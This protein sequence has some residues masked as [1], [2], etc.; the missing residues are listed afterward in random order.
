[1]PPNYVCRQQIF[2]AIIAQLCQATVNQD[3]NETTLTITGPG[4]IGKTSI[5]TALCHHHKIQQQFSDGF[6]FIELGPQATDPSMKLFQLYHLLKG[7]YLKTSDIN[8]AGKII[9]EL[10]H[11]YSHNLLVIIDD[12]WHVEDA[13]PIVKT[14]SKCKIVL[15]TRMND[16]EKY[17]P[18][19][20][21][22]SVGPMEQSEA[23]SLLTFS[24]IDSGK[25]PQ[26]DIALLNELA[27]D[28]YCWP[29][30]LSLIR[31]QLFHY[32]KQQNKSHSEAIKDVK[33]KLC[34]EGLTSF[35]SSNNQKGRNYAAKICI[36][37]TLKSLNK[38]LSNR[39]KSLILWTGIGTSLQAAVLCYL[40]NNT[41]PEANSI[42]DDLWKYG[43]IQHTDNR[44]IPHT[45]TQHHVQVHPIIS[46]YI[47]ESMD[48]KEALLLSPFG[49]LGTAN[50]TLQGL[51]LQCKLSYGLNTSVLVESLP[52]KDF[53]KF[54]LY[55]VE[56]LLIPYYL[57]TINMRAISDPHNII[58]NLN[59]IKQAAIS[60]LAVRMSLPTFGK[61]VNSIITKCH[62]AL[63]N[64]HKLSRTLNQNV[65]Q[66]LNER[67]YDKLH[68]SLKTYLKNYHIAFVAQ[69]AAALVEK[70]TPR[71]HGNLLSYIKDMSE[72]IYMTTINY[73]HITLSVVPN[74]EAFTKEIID[75]E[76]SLQVGSSETK[77]LHHT[78][79]SGEH[80]KHIDEI[81]TLYYIKVQEV[82]PNYAQKLTQGLGLR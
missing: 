3:S 58:Y 71:C 65:Q 34:T 60:S 16:I 57:K 55:Y 38:I 33:S 15:T 8:N 46:Q 67:D 28:I 61:E 81:R 1:M 43:L 14:F 42:V 56:N 22:V 40:W 45:S 77:K 64:A 70:V 39:L 73:H 24:V 47:M 7:K 76:S 69:E 72:P 63:N 53:L 32:I 2:D 68:H 54:R 25:L 20:R 78:Y 48:S 13:E 35:D 80:D 49:G 52:A 5:V 41:E 12:V 50:S 82:A 30:L 51:T 19:K 17:I 23:I 59:A 44:T 18:T 62:E 31:G 66:C 6:L 21:V 37:M 4:G 29:L 10:I 79:M 75:I 36:E 11:K 74:I 9:Q 27:Q 26:K